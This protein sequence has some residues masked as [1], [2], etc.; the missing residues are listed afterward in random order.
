M[1]STVAASA[2]AW[3]R[4][5]R[6][7][8]R[9]GDGLAAVLEGWQRPRRPSHC[10]APWART[11]AGWCRRRG[12]VLGLLLATPVWADLVWWDGQ[13]TAGSEPPGKLL[14][15]NEGYWGECVLTGVEYAYLTAPDAPADIWRDVPGQ[16]GRRL[17]D[18]NSDG[19][20]WVPV[21][22]RSGPLVV[23][24]DFHRLC[25]FAEVDVSTRSRR[26]G[27][28]LECRADT[29]SSWQEA[30]VRPVADCPDQALHRIPL[31]ALPK[32]RY[33]RLT[34]TTAAGP[35]YLDEVVAWG[36]AE[37]TPS[38][39]E[40]YR[41]VLALPAISGTTFHSIPGIAKTAL[42]DAEF[43]GWQHRLGP[44]SS[45]PAVWSRLPTW[46]A[47]TD[48]PILPRVASAPAPGQA[49]RTEGVDLVLARNET[50]VAALALT[51]TIMERP[52]AVRLRLGG[53]VSA[54][55][56]TDRLTAEVRVGGAIPSRDYGVNIG[57]L[58]A[59]GNLLG[60]SLMQRYLTN[61]AGIA[62]FPELTLSPSGSAVV[63]LSVRADNAAPGT[64]QA[65]L[66]CDGGP[67]LTLRA[68][69]LDVSL[70]QPPV[71]LQTWSDVTSMA[72]FNYGDRQE[73][74][75]AYKQGLG[76]T[77]WSGFPLPGTTAALARERGRAVFQVWGIGDYGHGLYNNRW[78]PDQLTAADQRAVRDLVRGHV[79]QA[80]ALGLSYDDW[81]VELTDEPGQANAALFGAFARLVKRADPR[82][83]IYC[84]PSFWVGW[85]NDGVA[86]D[87]PT[88]AA[89]APWYAACIDV[90]C[91]IFLLLE[92]R[93]QCMGL[94]DAPRAVR[95][96][97]TVSTQ[98]AKGE[99]PPQVELYRDQAWDAFAR[100]WNGWGFYSYYAPRG[101]PWD[102]LDRSWFEDM[103]DYLMVYP[104]PR[105]P[106]PTR[107]SE[108]VREGWEDYCLL[109]L[110]RDQGRQQVI[111]ELLAGRARGESLET[112]HERALR[113]AAAH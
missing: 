73:R 69:V 64:Y 23:V 13:R 98:S 74:E 110:L 79:A 63:W 95:A 20:G 19:N 81:Y 41:P 55:G 88:F 34:V 61:G 112:L 54:A 31:S 57:P 40:A 9:L 60:A 89:L 90:S 96:A 72:P 6:V 62:A 18:G 44:A 85:G 28:R 53:F 10:R 30:F 67:A 105:G 101:N 37:V 32:G 68:E 102:D 43:W 56:P 24:F 22:Q 93:P 106:V 8:L 83:R 38:L 17:L 78:R 11:F 51:S 7:P 99:R 49:A 50:E 1:S 92:R 70:P 21:G 5:T 77:V 91:P 97:Y 59:A 107:Q 113:A 27:L 26:V 15:D 35:A 94:F 103:P 65:T 109:S 4:G 75:V 46:G 71:W 25:T 87:D 80:R 58:F 52:N 48:G 100:G 42:S 66:E 3:G 39:P 76:A 104:G 2:P 16:F 82:V 47:L 84:N 111:S 36:G 86:A 45:L 12:L 29:V 33:L 108:A 14:S